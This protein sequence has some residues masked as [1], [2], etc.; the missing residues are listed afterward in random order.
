MALKGSTTEEKIWNY[1]VGNGLSEYGAAGLMGNLYAES[2]LSPTNLQNSYEKKL[3]YTDDTYT[4][5]VDN[6]DYQNFVRDSAGYGLAQWTFWSR[7]QNLLTF[8]RTRNKSIGDLETQL[9]FLIEEMKQSYSSVYQKL[10]TAGD[11]LGASNAVLLQFE[12][13]ADQSVAV[14]KKRAAYGQK[15]YEMM[16]KGGKGMSNSS[17]VTCTVKSPNHSG[18]RTHAIDRITPHCV[19]GQL[20]ASS[21]GGCFTSP[22][23]K[24]S[25]NYGIGT[26]GG[27][28]LVV[29]E[30]NR[31][32]CSS[33]GA[34]DQ[35]A[36]TIE[37]A[38]DKA[39]PYAFNST[40]YNKLIELCADICRRNGKNKLVWISDKNKALAYNPASNE[41]LLTVH[42]WFANKSCPGNWMYGRMGELAQKVNEKLGT[43]GVLASR[44]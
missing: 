41:M 15:Y 36:V 5:S 27:I 12:R 26:E 34:N 13:P 25:C 18:A 2:G 11:V 37:C 4:A 23:V 19:V 35:R 22:N 42:R 6:G 33:S 3:G 44:Y 14:Q 16:C 31:S 30:C 10:R 24:A 39:E 21:I 32:W 17:L 9:A 7:K 8:V 29:D 40:V 38:S 1:L 20:S 28:C 43:D